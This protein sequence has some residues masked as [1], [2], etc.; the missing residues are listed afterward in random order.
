MPRKFSHAMVVCARWETQ[1]IAEWLCYY[2]HIGFDHVYLYCNDDDPEEMFEAVM[3]F[4]QGPDPF[5]DF[6]HFG[7]QGF[8]REMYF[9]FLNNFVHECEWFA[10]F[11]VDE[12]LLLRHHD[13]IGDFIRSFEKTPDAIHFFWWPAG[14]NGHVTRP[15]GAV[16]SHYTRRANH[17]SAY[18]KVMVRTAALSATMIESAARVGAAFWHD[19]EPL[20]D[21]GATIVNVLGQDAR[22]WYRNFPGDALNVIGPPEFRAAVSERAFIFH[23]S[24]KSEDDFVRR[25]KRGTQGQFYGQTTWFDVAEKG[26]EHILSQLSKM[27]VEEERRLYDVWRQ[28]MAKSTQKQIISAPPGKNIALG[29]IALQS[30]VSVWSL[31]QDLATDAAG[32]INGKPKGLCQHHTDREPEPWW[33][34]DLREPKTVRQI[35]LLNR[36]DA[37]RDRLRNVIIKGSLDGRDWFT[38]LEKRDN[39]PFGGVDG[40]AFI[41]SPPAGETDACVT[42]FIRI[43]GVGES[44]LDFDQVEVY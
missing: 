35:R 43:C 22:G 16:L 36:I 41:W 30:S 28:M 8:Q 15:R 42:R 4:T 1:D 11:D 40:R 17:I 39:R 29:G 12:F 26:R 13:T 25:Y 14:N 32:V 33:Q 2:R 5:V 34:V 10:F 23:I 20:M 9:H 44:L 19:I 38:L 7:L 18:T 27:N 31:S 3:P 21:R 37:V 6:F 24:F